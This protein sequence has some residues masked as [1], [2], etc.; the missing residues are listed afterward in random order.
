VGRLWPVAIVAAVVGMAT[1][2]MHLAAAEFLFLAG[3]FLVLAMLSAVALERF[4]RHERAWRRELLMVVAALV[5]V[6]VLSVPVLLP[7][8]TALSGT[9]VMG[10]ESYLQLRGQVWHVGNLDL[11]KPGGMFNGGPLVFFPMLVLL[12]LAAPH[13]F[14]D[15]EPHALAAVALVS[16]TPLLL[17]DPFFTPLAL[18][19][20]SYMTARMAALM[21]FM[22]FVGIAWLL[23]ERTLRRD[24]LLRRFAWIAIALALLSATPDLI[25]TFTGWNPPGFEKGLDVYGLG[26]T[27]TWDVRAS[28]TPELLDRMRTRFGTSYPMVAAEDHTGYYLAGLEPV[29]VVSAKLSHSPAAIESV[30]GPQRRID[31]ERFFAAYTT[32]EERKALI[33]K[34]RIRYVA[35][36]KVRTPVVVEQGIARQSELFKLVDTS[37]TFALYEVVGSQGGTP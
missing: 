11:V 34:Y 25:R 16:M 22:P 10:A 33:E 1:A 24:D 30:D 12:V 7:K 29:T 27:Q 31:M 4:V 26:A 36:W 28:W 14:R 2:T 32:A 20:S 37:P 9:S 19:F 23:G 17:T 3:G 13:G 35:V 5:L 18:H 21:R 6:G 15:R 8:V